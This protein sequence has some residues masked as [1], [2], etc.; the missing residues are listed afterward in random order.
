MENYKTSV[1]VRRSALGHQRLDESVFG[2][3]LALGLKPIFGFTLVELLVVI[4]IIALLAGLLLPAVLTGIKKTDVTRAKTDCKLIETAMQAYLNEYGKF[5]NQTQDGADFEYKQN[6][7]Y[8]MLIATLRGT[9]VPGDASSLLAGGWV[10][11]NPQ[12]RVFLVISDNSIVTNSPGGG[13]DTAQVGQLAD[14]WGNRYHI[15][16]DWTMDGKI[17]ANL[18]DGENATNNVAVWSWGT[19]TSCQP[20]S[21]NSVHI[22][23]WR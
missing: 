23:S 21:K 16:A 15:V 5:P 2:K 20:N 3:P 4:A 1:S 17:T 19:D 18:A 9:N 13:V 22:R 10:N 7:D 12:N 6:N 11:Q 8:L 14:P